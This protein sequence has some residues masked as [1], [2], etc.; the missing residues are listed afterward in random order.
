VPSIDLLESGF[1]YA[2]DFDSFDSHWILS[3]DDPEC[4]FLTEDG[5]L[6]DP[7]VSD[8]GPVMILNTY[9]Q[10]PYVIEADL[11]YTPAIGDS[12]GLILWAQQNEAIYVSLVTGGTLY[13][14]LRLRVIGE[15]C[16]A[17][18]FASSAGVW[19]MVGTA[20]I[21]PD[22]LPGIYV[23]GQT[24]LLVKKVV[25]MRDTR[26]TVGN[27]PAETM[28]CLLNE[29][30]DVLNAAVAVDGTATVSINQPALF[31]TGKLQVRD[32]TDSIIVT[33]EIMDIHGGDIYWYNAFK[34]DLYHNGEL[35][36]PG[37]GIKPKPLSGGMVEER[38]EVEN[39]GEEY[40]PYVSV[41]CLSFNTVG[42]EQWVSLAHEV[43]GTPGTYY[44][45]IY[46]TGLAPGERAAFWLKIER[47][48]NV[49]YFP[50]TEYKFTLFVS[51]GSG[52]VG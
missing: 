44:D 7:A 29:Q 27:L 13:E 18:A 22:M 34:L 52:E 35:I 49:K 4:V 45:M 9:V 25:A 30:D 3:P 17:Y 12:A 33:S 19:E 38:L 32:L 21:P 10:A 48:A 39:S 42:G 5:L 31:F 6:L 8:S 1:I 46:L 16:E 50:F 43:D 28:I 51:T 37:E 14:R 40:V 24:P 41:R 23:E 11:D 36:P 26:V 2:T 15:R 20:F 47:P